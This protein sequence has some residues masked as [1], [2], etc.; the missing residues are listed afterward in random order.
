MYLCWNNSPVK[1]ISRETPQKICCVPTPRFPHSQNYQIWIWH[2]YNET[3]HT[4]RGICLSW[5]LYRIRPNKI[6]GHENKKLKTVSSRLVSSLEALEWIGWEW[7]NKKETNISSF[8]LLFCLSFPFFFGSNFFFFFCS[9]KCFW[10]ELKSENDWI[11]SLICIAC[12]AI[13]LCGLALSS[14]LPAN[15]GAIKVYFCLG[16]VVW[17]WT[18]KYFVVWT[19]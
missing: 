1:Q 9:L 4:H 7:K 17:R 16:A 3:D 6:F 14:L 11:N 5:I 19:H 8:L 12:R 13:L 18:A 2:A 10:F 15:K